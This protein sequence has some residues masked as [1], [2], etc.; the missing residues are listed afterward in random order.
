[1][2]NMKKFYRNLKNSFRLLFPQA[3]R[4]AGRNKIIIKFIISGSAA[5]VADLSLLYFFHG[6]IGIHLAVS[7]ALAFTVAFFISFGLQKFW[8]FGDNNR[9]RIY[10]QMFLYFGIA[11]F[12]LSINTSVVY[13]LAE[14]FGVWYILAQMIVGSVLAIGSFLFY[15]FVI[16]KKHEL[17]K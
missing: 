14:K 13:V 9:D 1:M 17:H 10:D 5:A 7:A 6:V 12:N 11:L 4:Q 2:S 8:T 16:F 3:Y 15:K